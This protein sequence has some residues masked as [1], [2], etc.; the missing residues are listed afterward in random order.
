[1]ERNDPEEELTTENE[2]VKLFKAPK[3][4]FALRFFQFAKDNLNFAP[5][6]K[7]N[8]GLE[9]DFTRPG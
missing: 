6:F 9:I 5:K 4:C 3:S 1:M 8:L 2:D 7:P